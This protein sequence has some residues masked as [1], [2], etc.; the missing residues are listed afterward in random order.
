MYS[1]Q[2]CNQQTVQNNPTKDNENPKEFVHAN[3]NIQFQIINAYNNVEKYRS[4]SQNNFCD[5]NNKSFCDNLNGSLFIQKPDIIT[6]RFEQMHV[7]VPNSNNTTV[8]SNNNSGND[9]INMK[10]EAPIWNECCAMSSQAYESLLNTNEISMNVQQILNKMVKMHYIDWHQVKPF[11]TEGRIYTTSDNAEFRCEIYKLQ[12]NNNKIKSI[13]TINRVFGD[14]WTFQAFREAFLQQ[15]SNENCIIL[16]NCFANDNN[17]DEIFNNKLIPSIDDNQ[18]NDINSEEK[19]DIF[20][21]DTAKKL[22]FDATDINEQREILRENLLL[23]RLAIDDENKIKI[24]YKIENIF[25]QLLQLISGENQLYDTWVIKTTLEIII[26]LIEYGTTTNSQ[27]EQQ[28]LHLAFIFTILANIKQ[29]WEN[30]F[31]HPMGISYFYPSQQIVRI[32]EHFN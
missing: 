16:N 4:V 30:I 31:P 22:L 29:K 32:C 15:L 9:D 8:Q 6:Q 18:N 19:N 5:D 10:N 21:L 26:K 11:Q 2:K 12:N 23:F 7:K 14:V 13:I 24:I 1:E 3:F 20:T 25:L 27:C 17:D 28:S